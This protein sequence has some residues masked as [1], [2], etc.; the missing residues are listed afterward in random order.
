MQILVEYHALHHNKAKLHI[1]ELRIAS[2]HKDSV[3]T[4]IIYLNL[5]FTQLNSSLE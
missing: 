2:E 1:Y 4:M 5:T 3:Q